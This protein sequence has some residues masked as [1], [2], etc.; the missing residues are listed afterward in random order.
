MRYKQ[1]KD[2]ERRRGKKTFKRIKKMKIRYYYC[3][4][5]RN[6]RKSKK[7]GR[8]KKIGNKIVAFNYLMKE[9]NNTDA[10]EIAKIYIKKRAKSCLTSNHVI[11]RKLYRKKTCCHFVLKSNI[12]LTLH[13]FVRSSVTIQIGRMMSVRIEKKTNAM[14]CMHNALCIALVT[15]NVLSIFQK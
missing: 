2:T 8:I 7:C 15:Y 10:F 5:Y 11:K 4:Y 6:E 1:I 12:M 14:H 9:E 13:H 3:V